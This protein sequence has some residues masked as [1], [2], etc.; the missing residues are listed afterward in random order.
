MTG[1]NIMANPMHPRLVE[2][3][4]RRL[5]LEL[6]RGGIT[7][8]Q[9][10]EWTSSTWW[11]LLRFEPEILAIRKSL[12]WQARGTDLWAWPQIL[13]RLPDED[14]TPLGPPHLDTLPEWADPAELRYRAIYGV[15]LTDTPLNG[16]HTIVYP[17]TEP[18][19][20]R[21][22]AGEVL[23]MSPHLLH[24]GS[25]N[26]SSDIRI[27]LFFRLLEKVPADG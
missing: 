7:P 24:S 4:R 1:Y 13:V 23:K 2:A 9:V 8:E 3:A 6:R 25:P 14:D 27:A 16:G 18:V 21:Q 15:E 20:V 10:N 26:L 22:A 19:V 12:A 17:W 11:P 5:L